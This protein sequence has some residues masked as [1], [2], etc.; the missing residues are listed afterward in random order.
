VLDFAYLEKFPA[1]G[2]FPGAENRKNEAVF[3]DFFE[4]VNLYEIFYVMKVIGKI[5]WDIFLISRIVSF[6]IHPILE[7]SYSRLGS[8]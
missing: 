1:I 3:H 2:G 8:Y 7:F 4:M 5:L 6:H